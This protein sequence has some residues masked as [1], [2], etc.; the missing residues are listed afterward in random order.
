MKKTAVF[1]FCV[2]VSTSCMT[3]TTSEPAPEIHAVCDSIITQLFDR[4]TEYRAA[5]IP[6]DCASS[7]EANQLPYLIQDELISSVFR[8]GMYNVSLYERSKLN[9]IIEEQALS[10]SGLTEET[11]EIGKLTNA[12]TIVTGSL[13]LQS[14]NVMVKVG[15]I[16]VKTG[17]ILNSVTQT[18]SK[19]ATEGSTAGFSDTIQPGTYQVMKLSLRQLPP[20]RYRV[21]K[22]E[23]KDGVYREYNASGDLVAEGFYT[24]N[25]DRSFTVLWTFVFLESLIGKESTYEFTKNNDHFS[26]RIISAEN[27]LVG[28]MAMKRL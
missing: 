7:E 22:I 14:S 4:T 19:T 10:L 5:I 1:L 28:N 16:D 26:I 15:L 11:E 27:T 17:R 8:T 25:G 3:T 6:L 18:M 9:R 13:Y 24:L 12:D 23:F 2:L 20:V 21:K